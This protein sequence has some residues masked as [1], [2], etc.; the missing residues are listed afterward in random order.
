MVLLLLG[1]PG[2]GKGTQAKFLIDALGIPQLSTGDMLRAAVKANTRLGQEAASFMQKGAL[3]PDSLVLGLI[4]ER[5]QQSDCD[6]GFI[7][8][9]FPRNIIQADALETVLKEVGKTVD[10]V[11]A[12]DVAETE[13]VERLTGRRTCKACGTGYHVKF[14]PSR[15]VGKCDKCGG[16]LIQRNDDVESVIRERLKVY[17]EQTTPLLNY[18]DKRGVLRRVEGVGAFDEITRRITRALRD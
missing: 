8:D 3:V 13:L 2:S 18:Y 7:L 11:V 4:R 10:R 9:G 6:K 15:V 14:Q 5:V 12:I 17:S 16:D 1:A